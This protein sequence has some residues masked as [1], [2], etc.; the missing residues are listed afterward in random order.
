MDFRETS[1]FLD[2]INEYTEQ[3]II[4]NMPDI[5]KHFRW[6]LWSFEKE[7]LEKI[8]EIVDRNKVLYEL[9]K[10]EKKFY[11]WEE[12]IDFP[13]KLK[14]GLEIEVANIPLNEIQYFFE[15]NAI[16]D[17]MEILGV[18]TD[19]SNAIIQN[20]DYQKKDEFTKWIFSPEESTDESEAS[21]PIMTNNLFDLNQI[22]AICTLFKALNARLHGGTGLHIN[23]GVD[24]LECNEKA[25]KNLLKIWGE[26]EELFFKMA[27]PEGEVIRVQANMMAVPIKENIQNFFE[28]DGSV[29]LNTEEDMERFLYQIQAR[30]RLNSVIAWANLGPEYDLEEDLEYAKTD[31]EKF[32]IYHRYE[33]GLRK[34]GNEKSR[35]RWTSI[36]FNHMKWNSENAGRIEIRIFNSS[37][38]P[39]I[40]FQDLELVGKIFEVS[41]RNAKNPSYKKDEFEKLFLRNVTE[42][43]KVNN[44][45]NL[46]FDKEKQKNI[47]RKRWYSINGES[48][49]KKYRSGIDTYER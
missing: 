49:Y 48:E 21:S 40:I 6:I 33:E 34:K 28:E 32:Q 39:K 9:F 18:P 25:I 2:H 44:L 4:Q 46:L 12:K 29:T 45:L 26:C 41:L 22:V 19:I 5:K 27:N 43:H 8:L 35:V 20:S 24:Y 3:E 14:F 30:N 11:H 16:L 47:F 10:D 15:S 38:E 17:I 36:N 7:Y 31:E 42:E 13:E 23:I 1:N 37:L